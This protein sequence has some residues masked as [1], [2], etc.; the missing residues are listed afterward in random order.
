[1][2]GD[3]WGNIHLDGTYRRMLLKRIDKHNDLL[4]QLLEE[5]KNKELEE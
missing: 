2:F 5:L 1:M 3:E 4:E